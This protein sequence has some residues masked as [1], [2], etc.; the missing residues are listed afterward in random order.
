MFPCDVWKSIPT[1]TSARAE[2]A[3]AL[4]RTRSTRTGFGLGMMGRL[5]AP[6]IKARPNSGKPLRR[7]F[8]QNPPISPELCGLD[9]HGRNH[10]DKPSQAKQPKTLQD[11]KASPQSLGLGY[12]KKKLGGELVVGREVYQTTLS[13]MAIDLGT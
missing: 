12:K 11:L 2:I 7:R 10:V 3:T 13:K 9:Y 8:T 1:H 6:S 4:S 5:R